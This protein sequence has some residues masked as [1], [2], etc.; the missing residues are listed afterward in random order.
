MSDPRAPPPAPSA[1]V[2]SPL[3]SPSADPSWGRSRGTGGAA[4][5][6]PRPHLPRPPPRL[7]TPR[8][9]PAAPPRV[10]PAA[11]VS[12]TPL[13]A[14]ELPA[15]PRR[16]PLPPPLPLPPAAPE[17]QPA[18]P[19]RKV[20]LLRRCSPS[21]VPPRLPPPPARTRSGGGPQPPTATPAPGGSR[22]RPHPRRT[23]APSQP[24]GDP[25]P[26]RPR[27]ARG[28]GAR[29]VPG[30]A[31][32]E[33]GSPPRPRSVAGASWEGP[34]RA[35]P[36]PTRVQRPQGPGATCPVRTCPLGPT[37][38][39]SLSRRPASRPE[40]ACP[41][42]HRCAHAPVWASF[43]VP[44]GLAPSLCPSAS[45]YLCLPV[46]QPPSRPLRLEPGSQRSAPPSAGLCVL[47]PGLCVLS[48][49]LCS[50]FPG[51][52]VLPPPSGRLASWVSVVS[53]TGLLVSLSPAGWSLRRLSAASSPRALWNAAPL[54]LPP[55]GGGGASFP[56]LFS[57]PSPVQG[58]ELEQVRGWQPGTCLS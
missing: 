29:V 52:P 32:R 23:G 45:L 57:T 48:P 47:S 15:A 30:C 14:G 9:S 7:S 31:R 42:P 36:A 55:Q 58:P 40:L 26:P 13:P 17:P 38:E 20:S 25:Q 24:A 3:S 39:S 46:S 35:V 1:S 27:L 21:S 16:L 19:Q 44:L 22:P 41:S 53:L 49:G 4:E 18:P 10:P 2:P 54:V 56:P 43:S 6:G 5:A 12:P 11:D 50:L 34:G 37:R 8:P 33:F 28:P 51:L